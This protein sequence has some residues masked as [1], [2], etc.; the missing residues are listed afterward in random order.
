[1]YELETYL[2]KPNIVELRVV[3]LAFNDQDLMIVKTDYRRENK[4]I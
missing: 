1:M 4:Y 3:I 2:N